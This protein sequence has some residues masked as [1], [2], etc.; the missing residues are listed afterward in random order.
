[1]SNQAFAHL[2]P[3]RQKTIIDC[4][5][6][7]FAHSGYAEAS[8]DAITKACGIAKGLLFHYFGSK[9]AFYLRCMRE[10]LDRL[11]VA[12]PELPDGGFYDVLFAS[13]D[14][15]LRLYLT[16]PDEIHFMSLAAWDTAADIVKEKGEIFREYQTVTAAA[17]AQ[18]ITRALE[19]LRLREPQ[20]ALVHDALAL[21][22]GAI[23]NKFLVAYR[24][25]PEA[26]FQDG[27]AIKAQIKAHIDLMLYGIIERGAQ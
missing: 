3:E 6:A 26:F 22:I 14:Q 8:T 23:N 4:G 2:P 11:M 27:E 21:Y 12:P 16:C 7:A 1:M 18:T 24:E 5:I 17:S 9:R 25:R 19:T 13:M 15:K 20:N 10:A